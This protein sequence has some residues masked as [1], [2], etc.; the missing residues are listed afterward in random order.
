LGDWEWCLRPKED[1]IS[2]FLNGYGSFIRVVLDVWDTDE[3]GGDNVRETIGSLESKMPALLVGLGRLD[4]VEGRVWPARFRTPDSQTSEEKAKKDE[5]GNQFKGYYLVGVSA[6]GKDNDAGWKKLLTGKVVTAIRA[7]ERSVRES[8]GFNSGHA[9]LDV[10]VVPKK[11]ISE[12]SL[13]A[14]ERDWGTVGR[15]QPGVC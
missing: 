4:Q 3:I 1:C 6:K 5:R 12:M 7:F 15:S 2:E 14:D 10:D 8:K 13:V 9:W 11:E